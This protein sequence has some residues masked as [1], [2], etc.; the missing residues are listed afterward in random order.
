[1]K[2]KAAEKYMKWVKENPKKAIAISAGVILL[3]IVLF[4]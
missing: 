3:L 4:G 2:I 1:M